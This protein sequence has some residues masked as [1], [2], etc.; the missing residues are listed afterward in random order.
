[1]IKNTAAAICIYVCYMCIFM[2]HG[3]KL[4]ETQLPEN[5]RII[6]EKERERERESIKSGMLVCNKDQFG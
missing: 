2:I 3:Y 4:L 6:R 1:M 5:Q